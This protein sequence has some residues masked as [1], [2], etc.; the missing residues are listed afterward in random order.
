MNYRFIEGEEL[1]ILDEVITKKDWTPINPK[2]AKA[3][4]AEDEEG[5]LKGFVVAQ[6][7]LHVEPMYVSPDARGEESGVS[8]ELSHKM[9]THLR[10]R[11]IRNWMAICD[12]PYAEKICKEN[13][14]VRCESPLYKG[15]K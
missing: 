13:G 3:L 10:E 5:N 11:G 7:M 8:K 1:Q 14:M 6:L 9:A 12:S 4:I 15:G 2:Y